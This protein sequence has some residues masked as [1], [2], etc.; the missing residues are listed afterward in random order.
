MATTKAQTVIHMINSFV[1]FFIGY[2]M[3]LAVLF[4]S[5]FV[6]KS[7]LGIYELERNV[8]KLQQKVEDLEQK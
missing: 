6:Y 5:V 8:A 1:F 2:A 7:A 3:L 4:G